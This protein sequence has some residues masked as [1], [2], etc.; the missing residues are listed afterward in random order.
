MCQIL[1]SECQTQPPIHVN[2]KQTVGRFDIWVAPNNTWYT[3]K[4][5]ILKQK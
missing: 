3:K 5:N 2:L 4:L 1:T